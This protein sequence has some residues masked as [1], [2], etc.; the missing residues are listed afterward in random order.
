MKSPAGGRHLIDAISALR[1][2]D[3]GE[4]VCWQVGSPAEYAEGRRELVA[5]AARVGGHLLVVGAADVV[6]P[7]P[8]VSVIEPGPWAATARRAQVLDAMRTELF[9][10]RRASASVRVLA[11]MEHLARPQSPFEDVL[12]YEMDMARLAADTGATLVCAYSRG[13]WARQDLLDLAAVH[14][15]IVGTEPDMPSFRMVRLEANRWSLEGSI[16]LESRRAFSAALRAA[17]LCGPHLRLWCAR[18][19]LIDAAG[20]RT[21]VETVGKT[22]GTVVIEQ[23][24]PMVATVWRMSGYAA[25]VPA[26]EV[27]T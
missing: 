15:R 20:L 17:L 2:L 11:G 7:S 14:S 25:L 23:A 19:E 6:A 5:H 27:R 21:L 18:L 22:T 26:I 9:E 13:S 4:H 16:G 24:S 12:V 1:A 8:C 10:A 3:P